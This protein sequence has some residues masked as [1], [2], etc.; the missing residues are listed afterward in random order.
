MF[1]I[2]KKILI[3][4]DKKIILSYRLTEMA[5]NRLWKAYR[6]LLKLYKTIDI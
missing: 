1:Y 2:N 5:E 4:T 3:T 6:K